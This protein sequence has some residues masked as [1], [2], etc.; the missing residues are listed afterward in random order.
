MSRSIFLPAGALLLA[1]SNLAAQ[2]HAQTSS[3]LPQGPGRELV[4]GMC[5]ACHQINQITRSSG[6]TREGW[7][8][9]TG[10]MV[11]LSDSPEEQQQIIDYL[12]THFPPSNSR[13]PRLIRGGLEVTFREW[14][15]PTLGQRA[16]DP[17]EAADG[18]IW[19]AGHGAI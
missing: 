15:A 8:E 10:T 16:R 5:T 6:Y 12:A 18:S 11:D 19:W 17:I 14:V 13:A 3:Q 1:L 4:D 2:V 7:K 9:L